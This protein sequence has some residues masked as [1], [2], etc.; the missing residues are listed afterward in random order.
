MDYPYISFPYIFQFLISFHC[1]FVQVRN[2][3]GG[4][5]YALDDIKRLERFII[6]GC[7]G[8]SYF[9]MEEKLSK[10]N[11]QALQR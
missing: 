10:E 3:M 1:L 4:Y 9:V 7:E 8:G 5:V 11:V 2:A 6:M